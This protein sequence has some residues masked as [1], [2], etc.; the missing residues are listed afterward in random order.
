[1]KDATTTQPI[2]NEKGHNLRDYLGPD[3]SFADLSED[4]DWVTVDDSGEVYASNVRPYP[5]A[6]AGAWSGDGL[7]WWPVCRDY[8][9]TLIPHWRQLIWQRP[10]LAKAGLLT[11]ETTE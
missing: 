7:D 5:I 1:M 10:A 2:L 6:A 9:F 8:G 3:W 11:D 4:Y